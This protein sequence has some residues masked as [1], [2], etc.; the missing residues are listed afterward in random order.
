MQAVERIG[1]QDTWTDYAAIPALSNS[2]MHD[3]AISPLRFWFHHIRPDREPKEETREM[4]FGSALH[5]AVLEPACFEQRYCREIDA[6]DIEGCLVTCDDIRQWLRDQG[7]HPKGTKKA[8]L[9]AQALEWNPE[10]P[11]LDVL[12]A[13]D[14]A[15]NAGKIRLSADEW[16]RVEG[17]ADALRNEPAI[18]ALLAEGSSE[19]TLTATDPDTGV[20]LKGRLDWLTP[21]AILDLKTF[22]QQR[23]KSIDKCITDAIW[24]ERYHRQA[25]LYSH[26][27]ALASGRDKRTGAQLGRDFV[28]AFVE[29]EPPHEVRIRV[30]RS[31]TSGNPNLYWTTAMHEARG[32]M[33]VYADC[34]ERF[35][36]KPWRFEQDVDPLIDEDIPQLLYTRL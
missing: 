5:C 29:S 21:K 7:R 23:G 10:A 14:E 1:T 28:L 19:V 12:K 2:G 26:I 13:Q 32:L 35:G 31:G 11:I 3:L 20:P 33:R 25:W 30:L 18:Q 17:C 8:D 22:S 6:A 4:R 27:D 24:Y 16:E 34:V 15:A 9:I 36:D